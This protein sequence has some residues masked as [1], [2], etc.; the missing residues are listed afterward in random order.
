MISFGRILHLISTVEGKV[1]FIHHTDEIKALD[2]TI[3][4]NVEPEVGDYVTKTVNIRTDCGYVLQC[5]DDLSTVEKDYDR[6]VSLQSTLFDVWG[7]DEEEKNAEELE[8]SQIPALSYNN[9][10]V[11]SVDN[12]SNIVKAVSLKIFPW[13]KRFVLVGLLGYLSSNLFAIVIPLFRNA[14][15]QR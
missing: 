4:L 1:K 6:I 10:S 14:L 5:H 15:L 3:L 7:S 8:I 11:E 12:S 2:S 13:I 9:L